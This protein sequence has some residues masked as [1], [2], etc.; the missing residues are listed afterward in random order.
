MK[1]Q[2]R[3][4]QWI[5]RALMA[6]LIIAATPLPTL[7]GD[8]PAPA[9]PQPSLTTLVT[10]AAAKTPIAPARSQTA[11]GTDKSQFE[12]PSFFKK[13]VGIAVLVALGAGVGFALYSTQN[14]RIT[15]PAKK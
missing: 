1:L 11:S 6:A 10:Q 4:S 13:P 14:D 8:P 5:C 15:S 2:V 12:S 9:P 3:T 7:A